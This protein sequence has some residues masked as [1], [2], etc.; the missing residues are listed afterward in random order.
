MCRC[1]YLIKWSRKFESLICDGDV[2]LTQFLLWFSSITRKVWVRLAAFIDLFSHF[3]HNCSQFVLHL[4]NHATL[5]WDLMFSIQELVWSQA[6]SQREPSRWPL[7]SLLTSYA[8]W[9]PVCTLKHRQL[10]WCINVSSCNIIQFL[11]YQK[12]V[13]TREVVK[14]FYEGQCSICV[15]DKSLIQWSTKAWDHLW[16]DVSFTFISN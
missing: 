1:S 14:P 11:R 13:K 7:H 6:V 4:L 8:H 16:T 2:V 9:P 5:S 3:K 10:V 15:K 12:A